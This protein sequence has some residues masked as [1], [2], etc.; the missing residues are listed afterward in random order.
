M[1]AGAL[2]N[3]EQTLSG[4]SFYGSVQ[5]KWE[6]SDAIFTDLKHSSARKLPVHSHELPFFG[7]V[8][9]GHYGERYCH[10][11]TQFRPFTIM[12]RPAGVPHQD[13]IGPHGVKLFEVEL[14]PAWRKRLEDCSGT[15]VSASDDCGGGQTLWLGLK[16]FRALHSAGACH[17]SIEALLA[18]LIGSVARLPRERA[19]DAPAW[20]SRIIDKLKSEH[21]ERLTLRELGKEAGVHPVHLSRVFRRCVGEGIGEFVHRLRIREACEQMLAPGLSL[22]DISCATGFADQSHLTRTFRKITGMT[23]RP[24]RTLMAAA[25][26]SEEGNRIS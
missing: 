16:L 14:R 8:L 23:P 11:Q 7:L 25:S 13:E 21:C 19:Q 10:R 6:H 5:G 12:F 15:L 2:E 3:R 18:E 17:L 9:A 24:F 4:G 22:A 1:A 26:L 20:L